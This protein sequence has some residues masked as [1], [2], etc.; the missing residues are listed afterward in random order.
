M[1]ENNKYY[2]RLREL[3]SH[4]ILVILHDCVDIL[5]PISPLE[6]AAFD[7]I[8]KKQVF[9][10]IET[11]KYMV[12]NFDGRKYPIVNYHLKGKIKP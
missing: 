7:C 11:G 12:F 4:E 1:E 8:S 9:N 5:T 2:E 6:M 3:P 10:R